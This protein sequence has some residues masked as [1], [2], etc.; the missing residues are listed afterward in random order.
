M[1][2]AAGSPPPSGK[3]LVA[4]DGVDG[5]GKST[6]ARALRDALEKDGVR[7][8]LLSVDDFRR[9]VDWHHGAGGE[10][11]LYYAR[12]FDLQALDAC[13]LA[14]VTGAGSVA[15][16]PYD[17]G[18]D[19]LGAKRVLS[20]AGVSLAILEGVF[21]LRVPAAARHAALVYVD[22]TFEEARRRILRRDV[23]R[24]RAPAEVQRRID[25]RYFPG[26]RRY[27]AEADPR[28]RAAAVV[29]HQRLGSPVL[30]RCDDRLPPAVA[31]ALRRI[32][33]APAPG[34]VVPS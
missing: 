2:A 25:G 16:D 30:V 9:P 31:R 28:R 18:T 6:L 26:Q 24:G 15:V 23:E 29:D 21:V 33:P 34:A 11:E 7:A 5:S 1:P 10:A 27:I 4:V 20:F 32:A 12:Y 8:A 17:G 19:R 14:F 13:V 22:V 3:Q